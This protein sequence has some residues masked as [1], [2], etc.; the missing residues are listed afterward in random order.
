[1]RNEKEQSRNEGTGRRIVINWMSKVGK[2][3]LGVLVFALWIESVS[4]DDTPPIIRSVAIEIKEVFDDSSKGSF[5]DFVNRAKI[6]TRESVI[7]QELLFKEGDP[8]NEFLVE[9]SARNLRALPFIRRVAITPTIDGD[10]VDVHVSVQ[11][12]W[13]LLPFF[14]FSTGGGQDKRLI[15]L[16]DSN[17]FG[18]GKRLEVLYADDEGRE[19]V[20]GVWDDRRFMGND[21]QLTVGHFYRSDGYRNAVFYGRPFRNFADTSAWSI[22]S[23]FSDLVDRLF[24][25]GDERYV[26]R[27]EHQEAS[28]AYSFMRGE[29]ESLIYRYSMG[30]EFLA[31]RFSEADEE[32]FEDIDVDPDSVSRDPSLLAGDREFSGPFLA[33]QRIERDFVAVNYLDRFERPEDFNLGN[34]LALKIHG[35]FDAF[36]SYEDA[37]L[38]SANDSDGILFAP[39]EFGRGEIGFTSRYE[40]GGFDNSIIRTRLKYFNVLGSKYIGDA[41][42]GRH[43]LAAMLAVDYASGLDKDKELLLGADTGLRG[44]ESRTFSGDKRIVGNFEDRFHLAE[45]VLRLFS[46]GGVLFFDWGA[47]SREDFDELIGDELHADF[48]VGLRVGFPRSSGGSVLRVD[49]AFPLRDGPDGSSEFELRILVTGGQMFTP[50]LFTDSLEDKSSSVK[51]DFF[52]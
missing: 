36:G 4:A 48:G 49:L 35:A 43:T 23:D 47:C 20:E 52:E 24:E 19:K 27:H 14:S 21:Q 42:I 3:F 22:S 8:F 41:F 2:S 6:S 26:F 10:N 9:E 38:I 7:R 30:Y 31:D 45:D 44:Y 33:L 28:V 51:V 17:L 34:H 40:D 25:A 18:Y 16:A 46:F 11:D 13:T 29:P 1:M 32:D 15:G 39:G 37:L 50:D 12:T 5:Y